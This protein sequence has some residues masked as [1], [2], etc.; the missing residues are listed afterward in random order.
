MHGDKNLPV[1][2]LPSPSKAIKHLTEIFVKKPNF[3]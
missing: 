3:K 1:L 2:R